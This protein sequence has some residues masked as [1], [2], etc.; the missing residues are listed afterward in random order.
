MPVEQKWFGVY[1]ANVNIFVCMHT[2]L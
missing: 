1:F 2:S